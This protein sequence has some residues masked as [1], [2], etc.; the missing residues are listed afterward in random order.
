MS[1]DTQTSETEDEYMS[2]ISHNTYNLSN[3][4]QTP[5]HVFG[6]PPRNIPPLM[7]PNTSQSVPPPPLIMPPAFDPKSMPFLVPPVCMPLPPPFTPPPVTVVKPGNGKPLIPPPFPPLIDP[8]NPLKMTPFSEP[9]TIPSAPTTMPSLPTH[10]DPQIIPPFPPPAIPVTLELPNMR[11]HEPILTPMQLPKPPFGQTVSQISQ[12]EHES[13]IRPP[14]PQFPPFRPPEILESQKESQNDLPRQNIPLGEAQ[15]PPYPPLMPPFGTS[16]R[17]ENPNVSQNE[18][19]RPIV[20]VGEPQLRPPFPPFGP[21]VS[22]FSPPEQL[23]ESLR[24]S[25][26]RPPVP[27]FSPFVPQFAPPEI[28]EKPRISQ[29][30]PP[31]S[32][33]SPRES[34]LLPPFPPLV[35][36]FRPPEI[37]ENEI[38][39][40]YLGPLGEPQFRPPAPSFRLPGP[41]FVP[42]ELASQNEP[43]RPSV[44]LGEPQIMPPFPPLVPPFRPPE[45]RE[46]PDESQKECLGLLGEPLSLP[47]AP[48][49]IPELKENESHGDP[50]LRPPF[51]P[52]GPPVSQFSPPEQES[53]IEQHNRPPV[54]PFGLPVPLFRPPEI[55]DKSNE[56]LRPSVSLGEPQ[57]RPHFLPFRPPELREMSQKSPNEPQNET[58]GPHAPLG[59]PQMRAPLPSLGQLRPIGEPQFRPHFPPFRPPE[60]RDSSNEP[61]RPPPLLLSP[62]VSLISDPQFPPNISQSHFPRFPP[63]PLSE[64]S[65]TLFTP[66]PTSETQSPL[67]QQNIDI[68]E[69][70][71]NVHIDAISDPPHSVSD[72]SPITPQPEPTPVP[73]FTPDPTQSTTKPP[74]MWIPLSSPQ[75]LQAENNRFPNPPQFPSPVPHFESPPVLISDPQALTPETETIPATIISAPKVSTSHPPIVTQSQAPATHS[76]R[77]SHL[78]QQIFSEEIDYD[79]E[80]DIPGPHY[81]SMPHHRPTMDQP[82]MRPHFQPQRHYGPPPGDQFYPPYPLQHPIRHPRYRYRAPMEYRPLYTEHVTM[83]GRVYYHNHETMQSFWEPPPDFDEPPEPPIDPPHHFQSQRQLDEAEPEKI[84]MESGPPQDTIVPTRPVNSTPVPGSEWC[85]VWTNDEKVFFFNA[86]INKS[87]WVIPP[88]IKDHPI[89]K[90]LMERNPDLPLDT[91]ES[92]APSK[93]VKMTEE[94]EGKD[95]SGEDGVGQMDEG[96]EIILQQSLKVKLPKKAKNETAINEIEARNIRASKSLEARTIEYKQMLLDRGVSAFSTWEKEQP[97]VA[98]D[99]RYIL[100]TAKERKL[101][102]EQFSQE[103]IHEEKREK[104]LVIK[105]KRESFFSLLQDAKIGVKSS[106]HDFNLKWSKDPRFKEIEKVRERENLFF[107]Y[108]EILKKKSKIQNKQ[109]TV[110]ATTK[111]I[112]EERTSKKDRVEASLREREREVFESRRNQERVLED[113]RSLHKRDE[114][115]VMYKSV[116]N[117]IV[118][119]TKADFKSFEKELRLNAEFDE[120][121]YSLSRDERENYFEHHLDHLQSKKRSQF[122]AC[123]DECAD[124]DLSTP[125]KKARKYI[126]NDIRFE[127]L[128]SSDSKRDNEYNRYLQS[129]IK[130]VKED[131]LQLLRE[132]KLITYK[133]KSNL[134]SNPKCLLEIEEL[135]K[136]DV[137]YLNLDCISEERRDVLLEYID[138]LAQKGAPPPPT[139]SSPNRARIK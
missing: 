68:L 118:K 57:L 95:S 42:P 55:Q 49:F 87:V 28:L 26:I 111:I 89:A 7:P 2:E 64:P 108:Q 17:M 107:E 36:P 106:Y 114:A 131:L 30:E 80:M 22:Q 100:F 124:I 46:N 96:I 25:H 139:A 23:H 29:N 134:E 126:K 112:K 121:F 40:E 88:E 78:P 53:H 81:H 117:E 109:K 77:F 116:L 74:D 85:V 16:I 113:Q 47:P 69:L 50:Q 27:T 43:I 45:L 59:D 122:Q 58:F 67:E 41:P 32:S 119:D 71:K 120:N 91:V 38:Q 97:K 33:A 86:V 51:P 11:H 65:V 93:R 138:E 20:S 135:L 90:K 12:P 137:R 52:F 73:H 24:E 37:R 82:F 56:S 127:G 133:T 62:P 34:Q 115:K 54:P 79:P 102:F 48:P 136:N 128:S 130:L 84:K 105:L 125:F 98:F 4:L 76:E 21:P 3:V 94:Q 92:E 72:S 60:L 5:A 15:L 35:P 83:E 6:P 1:S 129:K 123:I 39:K 70:D 75:A 104:N 110:E 18:P 31:M 61:L 44:S 99:P 9:S 13:H 103:R 132:T 19:I 63:P 10:F 14:V 66:H 101:V 8:N